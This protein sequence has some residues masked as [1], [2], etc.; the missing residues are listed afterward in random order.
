MEKRK[1]ESPSGKESKLS[2]KNE[3]GRTPNKDMNTTVKRREG[4]GTRRTHMLDLRKGGYIP[5]DLRCQGGSRE[6]KRVT[7]PTNSRLH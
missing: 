6:K 4:Q 5:G 3:P 7:N 2:L 1:E